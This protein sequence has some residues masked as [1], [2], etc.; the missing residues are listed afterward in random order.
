MCVLHILSR[1][2]KKATCRLC[3][4]QSCMSCLKQ[5]NDM[6]NESE[7]KIIYEKNKVQ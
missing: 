5:Q 2:G 3:L 7:V 4:R 6:E 1:F